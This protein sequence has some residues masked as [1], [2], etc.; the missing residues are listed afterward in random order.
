MME[1]ATAWDIPVN[2]SKTCVLHIGNAAFK[3]YRFK[4]MI[5]KQIAEVRDLGVLVK[6]DLKFEMHINMIV[7]KVFAVLFTIYRNTQCSNPQTFIRLYKAYVIP[8]LEYGSQIWNPSTRK[9]QSRIEKVQQTFTKI[10]MYRC[11]P[12][13][14]YP[15]T[16]PDYKKRLEFLKL[17]S[18]LFRRVFNDLVFAFKIV[19]GESK[20]RPSKYWIFRP[21]R[22][23][24]AILL[25]HYVKLIRNSNTK[26]FNNFFVDQLDGFRCFLHR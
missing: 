15:Y 4:D 2:L 25:I 8:I 11:F 22:G 13:P 5:L 10:L 12:D 16:M 18:L 9:L 7:R 14:G 19:K 17:D 23:R 6:S 20:L 21:C 26:M 1:W 3:E 24:N